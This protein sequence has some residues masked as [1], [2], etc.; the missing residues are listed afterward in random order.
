MKVYQQ[1][2]YERVIS[3]I[4]KMDLNANLHLTL[5]LEILK[6]KVNKKGCNG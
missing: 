2:K 4:P 6:V 1:V 3:N 5:K